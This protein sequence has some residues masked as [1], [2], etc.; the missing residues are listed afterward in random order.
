MNMKKYTL[1]IK[2]SDKIEK[3]YMGY[4]EWD[5]YERFSWDLVHP[6]IKT[7]LITSLVYSWANVINLNL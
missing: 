3:D 4:Q 6:V 1:I 5:S 7:Q 2:F